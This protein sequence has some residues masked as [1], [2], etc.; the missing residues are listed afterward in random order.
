MTDVLYCRHIFYCPWAPTPCLSTAVLSLTKKTVIVN[1]VFVNSVMW[2]EGWERG[3]R[4]ENQRV[5]QLLPDWGLG[6]MEIRHHEQE[7]GPPSKWVFLLFCKGFDKKIPC[8][9]CKY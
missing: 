6:W 5:E 1:V 2:A 8:I 3:D 7:A 9:L 4:G